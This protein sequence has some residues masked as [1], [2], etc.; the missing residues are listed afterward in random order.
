[1]LVARSKSRS[2][3]GPDRVTKWLSMAGKEWP[4]TL[5]IV[6]GVPLLWLG[7]F[8]PP[9]AP[10][11]PDLELSWYGALTHFSARGLQFGRDVVFTY[12]PLGHLI[13]QVYTGELFFARMTWEVVS[14][15]IF[16]LVLVGTLVSLPRFWRPIFFLFVLIFIRAEGSS[17]ALYFL[18]I[19]CVTLFL[20]KEGSSRPV[21]NFCAG[22]LFAIF[23]LIKFTY[24]LLVL[25]AL[26]LI[27]ACYCKL[28]RKSQALL[29]S[30]IF[31]A[32]FLFW[33]AIARQ[34]FHNLWS[35]FATS[36]E[37]SF[38][39]K[40][41]M[42]LPTS[43]RA[44][45]LAGVVAALL[46]FLQWS[47][48]LLKSREPV[49]LFAALF[50][51]G[52]TYLAW[53]RAFIRADDH[54]LS[55]FCLQPAILATMWIVAQPQKTVRWIGYSMNLALLCVCLFGVNQQRPGH[56]ISS[57]HGTLDRVAN[58][59]RI[60]TGLTAFSQQF[61]ATLQRVQTARALPK[62]KAEVRDASIDVLGSEQAI[63]ILNNL[64]YTPRPVFQGYSAYTPNLI[65]L[66][67]AFYTSPKAPSYVLSVLYSDQTIDGRYPTLD[68]AGVFKQVLYDYEPLFAEK[69]YLLWKRIHPAKP[70]SPIP[71]SVETLSLD[72]EHPLP[73]REMVWLEL[74]I[75]QSFVGKLR[76]L[77]YKPPPV[78]IR[79]TDQLGRQHRNRLVPSMAVAGFIVSPNL[80]TSRE[81]LRAVRG[82]ESLDNR[83]FSV[84]VAE[85][86]R[87][88]Y[89][90]SVT[91]RLARLP[92]IPPGE[93][94][95][96]IEQLSREIIVEHQE[97]SQP[98][99][100]RFFDASSEMLRRMDPTTGFEA[101]SPLNK[102]VFD[103]DN[104]GLRI[105]CTGN[106]PQILLPALM[107]GKQRAAI[108]RVELAVPDATSFQVNSLPGGDPMSAGQLLD[109]SL[110]RGEN[111][112]YF[113]LTESQLAG[114]TLVA[115]TGMSTG[116][117]R[118]KE[119]EARAVSPEA[120]PW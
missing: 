14:K 19:C 67:T 103:R 18:I 85:E 57:V 47:V 12:G 52:E 76:T 74:E 113:F 82:A 105:H 80:E 3:Q 77:F 92:G 46:G 96:K 56:L 106:D 99:L 1:M 49:L 69:R 100:Q 64:N 31:I 10:L 72:S 81:V 109:Q 55:F 5:L 87:Q 116:E 40:E 86:D 17:D 90:P 34:E 79:V 43:N 66:N 95:D 114:G 13:S 89:Q 115:N 63:A 26:S 101:V 60:A 84:H 111:V 70:V 91:C 75:K 16:V 61:Q 51:T 93:L 102:T 83:S 71:A 4:T 22:V 21:F 44:V 54:V 48:V 29:L 28:Q 11:V 73:E 42:A 110:K 68:D 97:T 9:I 38:G 7:L 27:V 15:T 65:N 107:T 118:I 45:L 78:A 33:W 98:W 23:S 32:S 6:I 94:D 39:Y 53:N 30:L 41:A 35:Y 59:W 62:V 25:V 108:F 119:I 37:I 36:L 2:T 120:L 8:Q 104:Q 20:L 50:I 112:V 24:F 58:S 88:F 117:Y